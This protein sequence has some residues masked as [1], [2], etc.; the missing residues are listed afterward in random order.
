MDNFFTTRRLQLAD[1][2]FMRHVSAKLAGFPEIIVSDEVL[3]ENADEYHGS[4]RVD[5]STADALT[6]RR[7]GTASNLT[8]SPPEIVIQTKY[9]SESYCSVPLTAEE[10]IKYENKVTFLPGKI[11]GD[12]AAG[13]I[14]YL[15]IVNSLGN[16]S[17]LFILTLMLICM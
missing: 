10:K 14:I 8:S 17:R 15:I 5:V 3:G 6:D 9:S 12:V 16:L 1:D 2:A 13:I 7:L 11:V 4:L